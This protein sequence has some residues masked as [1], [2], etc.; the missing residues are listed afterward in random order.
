V[1]IDQGYILIVWLAKIAIGTQWPRPVAAIVGIILQAFTPAADL[2]RFI[3]EWQQ[4][5]RCRRSRTPISMLVG[6]HEKRLPPRSAL[7]M[8]RTL[9]Y[10][11]NPF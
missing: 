7:A 5:A 6:R 4:G 8:G 3:R 9:R 10:L 2:G 1:V 11:P